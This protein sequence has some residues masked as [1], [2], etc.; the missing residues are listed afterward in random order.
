MLKLDTTDYRILE[1]LQENAK[2]TTKEVAGE[3][4]LSI[5]PV[6]ERIKRLERHKII[7][8]HVAL[9]DRKKIGK[10]LI[11]FCNVSLNQHS[12]DNLLKF[13]QDVV[14]FNEVLECYHITGKFDYMIKIAVEDMEAYHKFTYHHLATLDNVGN[15]HTVFAMNDIKY[16]TAYSVT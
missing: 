14:Q 6:Y 9:V 3:L 16:S 5:T 2:L 11:G 8:K 1:M 15:V 10:N 7:L 12:K 13:E 4:G